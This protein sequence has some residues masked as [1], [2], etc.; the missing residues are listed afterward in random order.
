MLLG[1]VLFRGG[2]VLFGRAGVLF[3]RGGVGLFVGGGVLVPASK[4]KAGFR[5]LYEI[6]RIRNIIPDPEF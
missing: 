1:G 2:G 4:H 6:D 3:G 5:I